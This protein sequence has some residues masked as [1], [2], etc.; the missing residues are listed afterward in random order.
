MG[1]KDLLVVAKHHVP[2]EYVPY[3]PMSME[4]LDPLKKL[5]KIEV[6]GKEVDPRDNKYLKDT[7]ERMNETTSRAH[8]NQNEREDGFTVVSHKSPSKEANRKRRRDNNTP[9]KRFQSQ[10]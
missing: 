1:D 8:R 7:I 4:I 9:R 5:P 3:I 6:M 10:T 2:N